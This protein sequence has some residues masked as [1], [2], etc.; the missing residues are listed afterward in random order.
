MRWKL[1]IN[2]S[3]VNEP[4]E[5]ANLN[6]LDPT[7]I[8]VSKSPKLPTAEEFRQEEL[9]LLETQLDLSNRK[10]SEPKYICPKCK[11][12]GMCKDE[13]MILTSNPPQFRYECMKCHYVDYHT[14]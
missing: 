11:E 2:N 10:W 1:D 7:M 14:I 4:H 8:P 12:G 13:T 9:K 3:A 5:T 6:E